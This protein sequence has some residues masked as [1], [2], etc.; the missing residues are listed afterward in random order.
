MNGL[1]HL[2]LHLSK[3]IKAQRLKDPDKVPYSHHDSNPLDK[4]FFE[5]TIDFMTETCG[6]NGTKIIHQGKRFCRGCWNQKWI[7]KQW[8]PVKRPNIMMLGQTTLTADMM[9]QAYQNFPD[10]SINVI[11]FS[12]VSEYPIRKTEPVDLVFEI[13]KVEPNQ[14]FKK[15]DPRC[16]KCGRRHRNSWCRNR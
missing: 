10:H 4:V 5:V 8:Q 15:N 7:E 3:A 2:D 14:F 6:H 16:R 13:P 12:E 11:E 9:I 1:E